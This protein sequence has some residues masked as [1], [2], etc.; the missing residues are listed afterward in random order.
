MNFIELQVK[1]N[2]FDLSIILKLSE[3]ALDCN[4]KKARLF[5]S[6][7]LCCL[8]VEEIA[9]LRPS[10]QEAESELQCDVRVQ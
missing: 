8:Q 7:F 5:T 3:A 2:A 1:T 10:G 9:Q 6:R 4:K